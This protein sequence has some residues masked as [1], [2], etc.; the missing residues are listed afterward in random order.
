MFQ[1]PLPVWLL[2]LAQALGMCSAPLVIFVGGII[3]AQMAPSETLSTLP[4]ATFIIGTAVSSMPA[5]MIMQRIGRRMGFLGATLIAL[6]G[7]ILGYTSI[8]AQNFWG[9]CFAVSL[10]GVHIAFVAQFRFAALEWVK[11]EQAPQAA[12]V[13]LLGGLIAAFIGPEIAVMG[14]DIMSQSFAGSFVLLAGVHSVLFLF[15]WFMP[16][17]DI[18]S[19]EQN[20]EKRPLSELIRL[21]TIGAAM[22]AGAVGYGVMSLIMTATPV[23]MT[24]VQGFALEES[25]VV[26]QT[27]ILA[28]FLPA[29]FTPFLFRILGIRNIMI[30]GLVALTCAISV[31]LSGQGYW[32]YWVALIFLGVGWNFLFVSGTGLL[33]QTYTLAES[34]KVQAVNEGIVFSS[35]ALM[36]LISGWLVFSFGWHSLNIL[37]LLLMLLLIAPIAR[38]VIKEN[39]SQ[40][41]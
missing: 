23:S 16:Y 21:P 9:L 24:Q 15:L 38:W 5:A 25:K 30:L 36:S 28:M 12:S 26:I 31:A 10:L 19:V 37:A 17:A 40:T 7:A 18:Q 3:G 33:A 27:H 13:V 11:A 35:Q 32:Y 14:K 39:Q 8:S 2:S 34:F 22:A 41:V 20:G 6:L 29:L 4:V 1:L